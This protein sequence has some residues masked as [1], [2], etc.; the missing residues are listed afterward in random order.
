LQQILELQ[1][2]GDKAAA[3]RFIERYTT[4]NPNLHEVVAKNMRATETSR[5]RLV[6]YA[7]LGE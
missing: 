2:A 4:W 7:A 3:D 1:A 5:Y 6:R